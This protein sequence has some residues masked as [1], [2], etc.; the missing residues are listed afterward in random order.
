MAYVKLIDSLY[1][2]ELVLYK[3]AT[4]HTD[5]TLNLDTIVNKYTTSIL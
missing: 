5:S 1:L 4:T 3:Q 2:A